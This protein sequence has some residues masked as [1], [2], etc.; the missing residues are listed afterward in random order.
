MSMVYTRIAIT[1][2][3]SDGKMTDI[4]MYHVERHVE[5][6]A[7]GTTAIGRMKIEPSGYTAHKNY[8]NVEKSDEEN[9]R[10]I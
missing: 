9:I 10:K 5:R 8:G 1:Y 3:E 2:V 7:M 6:S 4:R